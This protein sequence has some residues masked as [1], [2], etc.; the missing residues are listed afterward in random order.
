MLECFE[1]VIP[2]WEAVSGTFD[3]QASEIVCC[4]RFLKLERMEKKKIHRQRGEKKEISEGR[5]KECARDE[6]GPTPAKI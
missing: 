2:E 1:C 5:G 3:G 6:I 4:V